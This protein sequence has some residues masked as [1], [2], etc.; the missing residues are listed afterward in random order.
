MELLGEKIEGPEGDRDSTGISIDSTNLDPLELSETE[1]PKR[2]NILGL[3]RGPQHICSRSAARTSC[4]SFK[5]W[6]WGC[7]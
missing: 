4:G 1:A 5:N 7:P 3:N 6:S 2:K